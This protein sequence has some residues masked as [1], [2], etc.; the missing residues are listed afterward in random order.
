MQFRPAVEA[1]AGAMAALA[2]RPVDVLRDVIH[3]RSVRV[4]VGG[5]DAEGVPLRAE[6]ADAGGRSETV[7]ADAA[8]RDADGAVA[9]G[10]PAGGET[11]VLSGFVCYDATREAVHVTALVGTASACERLLDAPIRFAE[12]ETLPVELVAGTEGAAADAARA[13][14]FEDC[15]DGPRFDGAATRRYRY[16]PSADGSG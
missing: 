1:D 13:A 5:P 7:T 12:C 4:A 9:D 15:G 16:R 3:D 6:D 8:D 11:G 10:Q 2:D 14:G